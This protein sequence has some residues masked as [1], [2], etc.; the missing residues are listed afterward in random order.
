MR[1]V[2]RAVGSV[3]SFGGSPLRQEIGL[4]DA[5]RIRRLDVRWP[6]SGVLQSFKD[7][8]MNTMIR[9]TEGVERFETIQLRP[10]DL[11]K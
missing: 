1:N 10:N 5:T 7:V 6:V 2:H 4:G 11:V 3:S 8:P 9:I